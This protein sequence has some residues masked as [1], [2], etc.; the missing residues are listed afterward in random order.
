MKFQSSKGAL[1]FR[2]LSLRIKVVTKYLF[3]KC[4][5]QSD[6]LSNDLPACFESS[7]IAAVYL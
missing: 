7:K 3:S 2:A 6:H 1:V 4:D 5:E